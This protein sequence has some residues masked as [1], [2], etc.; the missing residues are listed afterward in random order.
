MDLYSVVYH[1][2]PEG[3]VLI[4]YAG[5]GE[6]VH[7]EEVSIVAVIDNRV[8]LISDSRYFLKC[9]A[10]TSRGGD[11]R[12]YDFGLIGRVDCIDRSPEQVCLNIA[13]LTVV[14]YHTFDISY[15]RTIR[16]LDGCKGKSAS[17]LIGKGLSI[18]R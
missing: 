13:N 14:P 15:Y 5:I 1:A 6:E 7:T 3:E 4:V 18:T 9:R 2:A 8:V 16:E 12:G 17:L 10:L 11:G